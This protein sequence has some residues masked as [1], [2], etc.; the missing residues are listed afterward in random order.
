MNPTTETT[1]FWAQDS[2]PLREATFYFYKAKFIETA[3]ARSIVEY[4]NFIK[5]SRADDVTPSCAEDAR[6]ILK[7]CYLTRVDKFSGKQGVVE[8]VTTKFV[9]GR[10]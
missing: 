5:K 6:K 4:Q 9:G 3:W 2:K 7:D 8:C 10:M 1:C